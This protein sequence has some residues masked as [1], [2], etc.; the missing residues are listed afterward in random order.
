LKGG[1]GLWES[2][3]QVELL[4]LETCFNLAAGGE[5]DA[6][7]LYMR[8][9]CCKA[10]VPRGTCWCCNWQ[11]FPYKNARK[12]R[13]IPSSASVAVRSILVEYKSCTLVLGVRRVLGG[14]VRL[15]FA[16]LYF[17]IGNEFL[18]SFEGRG[19]LW[20]L[21]KNVECKLVSRVKART[22]NTNIFFTHP[23]HDANLLKLCMPLQDALHER[24]PV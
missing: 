24:F 1:D 7:P 10:R 8:F 17:M 3:S 13:E 18:R 11:R 22:N 4:M 16:W 15:R 5:C 2:G 14:G 21:V 12:P 9:S 23:S 6:P 19:G 20:E